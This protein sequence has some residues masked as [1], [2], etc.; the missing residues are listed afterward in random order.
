MLFPN[1]VW[2][3]GVDVAVLDVV[4]DVDWAGG[5]VGVLLVV[6]QN[7]GCILKK[8]TLLF[9]IQAVDWLAWIYLSKRESYLL[10]LKMH[11]L[12]IEKIDITLVYTFLNILYQYILWAVSQS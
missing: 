5:Q 1:L 8:T 3:N 2:E 6:L 9:H 12:L 4:V 7:R 10:W 11:W